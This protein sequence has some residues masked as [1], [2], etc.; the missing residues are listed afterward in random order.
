MSQKLF[1]LAQTTDDHSFLSDAYR[2]MGETL[3]WSGDF[4]QARG[5]FEKGIDLTGT[6]RQYS[7]FAESPDVSCRFFSAIALWFLGY[8]DQALLRSHEAITRAQQL[9]HPFSLSAAHHFAGW[10]R[11]LRR[12]SQLTLEHAD[13][14]MAIAADQG[15]VFFI[16]YDTMLKGWAMA[17][18]GQMNAGISLLREGLVAYQATGTKVLVPQWMVVLAELYGISG[19]AEEALSTLAE[20]QIFSDKNNG[21]RYFTAEMLRLKG[22]LLIQRKKDKMQKASNDHESTTCLLNAINLA[23]KQGAKSLELRAAVSLSRIWQS[24]GKKS[25]A[26]DLLSEIYGWF[27]EGFD[28]PDL[29]AAKALLEE[30]S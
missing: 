28:T 25:D 12:E 15:F 22:Q 23:Q 3:L 9:N 29:I 6:S 11:L 20:A 7:Y 26:F 5:Y 1:S 24:Q 13:A 16:A 4:S 10:L 21:E 14:A 18:N 8:P 19:Q 30:L 2:A 27:E 17:E